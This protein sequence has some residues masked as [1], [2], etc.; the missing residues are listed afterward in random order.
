MRRTL[1]L[2]IPAA[3][4]LFL[5]AALV[6]SGPAQA[7]PP[8]EGVAPGTGTPGTAGPAAGVVSPSPPPSLEGPAQ[9][10][11][12]GNAGEVRD[13]GGAF[14][15]AVAAV[16]NGLIGLVEKLEQ[17][18]GLKSFD[19]LVYNK[20]VQDPRLGPFAGEGVVEKLKKWYQGMAMATAGFCLLAVVFTSGKLMVSGARPRM[21]EEAA[22]S[23][24][25]WAGAVAIIAFAPVLMEVL[26]ELNAALVDAIRSVGSSFVGGQTLDQH[27][28]VSTLENL[29]TGSV[30]GTALVKLVYAGVELYINLLYFVRKYALMT[31]YVFTPLMA[32]LWAFNKNVNAAGIWLGEV[33]SNVFMQSAHALVFTL[34]LTFCSQK[35]MT[36]LEKLLWA[37]GLIPIAE[38]VRNSVQ[39]LFTRLSGF[40]EAGAVG[41]F[42]GALG[43]GGIAGM[44][45]LGAISLNPRFGSSGGEGSGFFPPGLPP[46]DGS[47]RISYDD[48]GGGLTK[49]PSGTS[50][51]LMAA[52]NAG[53]IAGGIAAKTAGT[54]AGLALS[55]VGGQALA[56]GVAYGAESVGRL[57]GG[58][59]SLVYQTRSMAARTKLP[60]SESF[61]MV[62]MSQTVGEGVYRAAMA[63]A[64]EVLSPG[65]SPAAT[66]KYVL[67]GG[68]DG[69]KW[70]S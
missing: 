50:P 18:Q 19:E 61:K 51:G 26:F 15:R 3:V 44:S 45:R 62:T 4:I 2:V 10:E 52:L 16:L 28:R 21:R 36:W 22:E 30:L 12:G 8:Y 63:G 68:L 20:G 7:W 54:M 69:L 31:I 53:R 11:E 32:W 39:G 17:S 65:L 46:D 40:D 34:F 25:R 66:Q 27:L 13:V 38:M 35:G 24:W 67:R 5:A 9:S 37:G 14:E 58:A 29:R 64:A 55:P 43:L 47:G 57:V 42:L 59:G 33:I 23:V 49:V 56:Q 1:K 6:L 70:R 41:K 60:L 48:G